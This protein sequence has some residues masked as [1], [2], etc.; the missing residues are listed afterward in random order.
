[1]EEFTLAQLDKAEKFVE[2]LKDESDEEIS[3][4]VAGMTAIIEG[5]EKSYEWLKNQKWFERIWCGLTGKNKAAVKEMQDKRESLTKYTV[6]I[7]I[8]MNR[9]LDKHSNCIYDLYRALAVVRRDMDGLVDEVNSLAVK[10]NEKII[11]IDNYYYLLNEIRNYKFNVDTPLISLINIMS[12]IDIRTANDTKKLNQL[13]ETME[14]VGFDFSKKVDIPAYSEEILSLPEESIGRILLFCQSFSHRSRF[15]AYTCSLMENYYYLWE[16]D[17]RVVKENGEAVKAAMYYSNLNSEATC[18]VG[19]LFTDLKTA[20]PDGFEKIDVVAT[21]DEPLTPA[22]YYNTK[23]AKPCN[24][25]VV[26]NTGSG[27]STLINAVFGWKIAATGRGGSVTTEATEYYDEQGKIH[28]WEMAGF[29]LDVDSVYN[30]SICSVI[31]SQ[32]IKVKNTIVWYCVDTSFSRYE[33]CFIK[34]LYSTGV[35]IVIVLTKSI[36]D[37]SEL[38]EEI[39]TQNI[40]NGMNNIP[41]VPLLAEEIHIKDDISIPAFGIETL[42]DTSINAASL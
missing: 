38:A 39:K 27:K 34:E 22:N 29:R 20:L 32:I 23:T 1:M 42:I 4:I 18:V 41:V 15:L 11:S 12:L 26:G 8:I 33:D 3:K 30:N 35:P 25:I 7:L 36:D 37:D 21:P 24:I 14:H 9:L 13:K 17:K 31:K 40:Y 28:F 10:L 16:S 2:S 5:N 19:E 6:Q